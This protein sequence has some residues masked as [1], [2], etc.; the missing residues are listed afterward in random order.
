M[1]DLKKQLRPE[2]P[3][4]KKTEYASFEEQFQNEVLRPIIKLQH[5]LIL[6][7]FAHVLERNKIQI[8]E[9]DLTQKTRILQKL[10]KTDLHLKSELRGLVV[11]LFTLAEYNA[12]LSHSSAL[13]RRIYTMIQ[14]RVASVYL[15]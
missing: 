1:T 9:L 8:H 10:F 12:Y 13:N 3:S 15:T 14:E 4:I 5:E 7:C 2:I 11:G 6:S